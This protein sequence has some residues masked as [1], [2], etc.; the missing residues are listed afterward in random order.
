MNITIWN[1]YRHEQEN[2]TIKQIYPDGI[3]QVIADCLSSEHNVSTATLDEPEHGLTD[4][5]LN[6]TDVLIW[7]G[8][9]A[10]DEV[11]DEV[12]ERLDNVCYK[13]WGLLYCIQDIFLKFS[14]H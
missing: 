4:E 7:W 6:K 9:K 8:H 3:H 13:V 2:E 1:E 5:R 12:V 10:H 11:S 14:N